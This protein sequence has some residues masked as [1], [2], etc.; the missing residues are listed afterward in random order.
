METKPILSI[1]LP[2]F[3]RESQFAAC[4]AELVN[5]TLALEDRGL[6]EIIVSNNASTDGTAAVARKFAGLYSGLRYN[7]NA[8]DLG[9]IENFLLLI[10]MA[11]GSYFW[12]VGDDDLIKPGALKKILGILVENPRPD[13]FYVN[14]E[15]K[16]SEGLKKI[17]LP[18]DMFFESGR[19]Y[20][21]Y[22]L[23]HF[24]S[25]EWDVAKFTFITSLIIRKERWDAVAEKE[26]FMK[27]AAPHAYVI[28]SFLPDRPLYLISEALAL[29]NNA[30]Y[31]DTDT[32]QAATLYKEWLKIFWFIGK[33]CGF[34]P[35]FARLVAWN[36]LVYKKERLKAAYPAVKKTLEFLEAALRKAFGQRA[37]L[38]KN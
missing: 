37:P 7:E 30:V 36:C 19:E 8:A 31:R 10:K 34:R 32:I 5:Q 24:S 3:N 27:T 35:A 17:N 38:R 23:R 16:G 4:L 9:P 11:R 13:L 28:F 18:E 14:Y 6:V 25:N 12:L 20:V 22:G 21:R 29:Q 26:R 2:T 15:Q 1:C 33:Q